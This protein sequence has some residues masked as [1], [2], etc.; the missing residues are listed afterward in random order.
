MHTSASQSNSLSDRSAGGCRPRLA[1]TALPLGAYVCRVKKS[2]DVISGEDAGACLFIHPVGASEIAPGECPGDKPGA[3][4]STTP[5]FE[6]GL[7]HLLAE[8]GMGGC[9]QAGVTCRHD[10]LGKG[11]PHSSN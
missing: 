3:I 8:V 2:V 5:F 10:N 4:E 11:F 1:D 7:H 6:E 9:E